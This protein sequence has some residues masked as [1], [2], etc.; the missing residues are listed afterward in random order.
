M[1]IKRNDSDNGWCATYDVEAVYLDED[2]GD[3]VI[4]FRAIK[5]DA[6]KRPRRKTETAPRSN[7]QSPTPVG[8]TH[9]TVKDKREIKHR[10]AVCNPNTGRPQMVHIGNDNT[11]E[12]N[13]ERKLAEAIELRNRFLQEYNES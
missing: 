4:A 1:S 13:W 7:K 2:F 10:F 6:D 5:E 8:I 9:Y 3:S 12:A 11:Y